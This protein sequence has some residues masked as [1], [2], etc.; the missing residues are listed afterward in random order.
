[1]SGEGGLFVSFEGGEG[2]GKSTQ[3]AALA[4]RL[5]EGGHAVVETREPGGTPGADAVREL[6]LSGGAERYGA[7]LEAVLFAAARIDH[8]QSVIVPALAA[9]AV[10]LCDRFHDSTRVY[11][12]LDGGVD[13]AFLARLE[14]VTLGS[15]VPDVTFI[16]DLPARIGLERAAVR[17][18]AARA[19][20]FEK[21][22]LD[23]QERRR[24]AFLAIAREEPDR[25]LVV[26]AARDAETIAREIADLVE[27]RLEARRFEAISRSFG[28]APRAGSRT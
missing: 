10:V 19:D 13:A 22:D 27:D 4:R 5:R 3:L 21:D 26:D 1:M 23:L 7:K 28:A 12:G 16:L 14:R 15:I 11:Q 8:I 25:C 20:R 2:G 17:R 6:V 9:G 18:G 24:R